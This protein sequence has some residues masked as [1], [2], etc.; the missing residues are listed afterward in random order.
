MTISQPA[1][2]VLCD[3]CGQDTSPTVSVWDAEGMI[4]A[5]ERCR[6]PH[7]RQG[8]TSA[9][10]IELAI[11]KT[12][13]SKVAARDAMIRAARIRH[14]QNLRKGNQKLAFD[15]GLGEAAQQKRAARRVAA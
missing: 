2:R 9:R 1:G 11:S 8:A 13:A 6:E 7:E 4:T 10:A 3:A 15:I 5:C 12:T 14:G